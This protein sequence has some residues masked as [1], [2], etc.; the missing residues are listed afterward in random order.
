MS[1]NKFANEWKGVASRFDEAERAKKAAS[2]QADD[3]LRQW[4]IVVSR[5]IIPV[6]EG[7]EEGASGSPYDVQIRGDHTTAIVSLLATRKGDSRESS[8]NFWADSQKCLVSVSIMRDGQKIPTGGSGVALE[9]I[10]ADDVR[11]RVRNFIS[12]LGPPDD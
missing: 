4:S 3:F 2:D 8:L 5:E 10:D 7:A 9:K 6:L 11:R 1:D 12:L